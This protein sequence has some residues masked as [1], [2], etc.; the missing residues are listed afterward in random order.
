MHS[1]E[2]PG[3]LCPQAAPACTPH[4]LWQIHPPTLYTFWLKMYLV[5]PEMKIQTSMDIIHE[6]LIR[7]RGHTRTAA[8]V[9]QRLVAA[10][11][12]T[13]FG[14][15]HLPGAEQLLEVALARRRQVL[16]LRPSP[17]PHTPRPLRTSSKLS[18]VSIY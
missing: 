13:S 7:V 15:V 2:Y 18:R 14:R 5:L 3:T 8:R 11:K 6:K 16:L 1:N 4:V 17:A 10:D 12:A 9:C